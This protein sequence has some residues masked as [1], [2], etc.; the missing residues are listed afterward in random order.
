MHISY[1]YF[2]VFTGNPG[3]VGAAPSPADPSNDPY[4]EKLKSLS[5]YLEPLRRMIKKS[6]DAKG[7]ML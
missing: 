6:E 2:P 3:S 1:E 4:L 7:I 5:I